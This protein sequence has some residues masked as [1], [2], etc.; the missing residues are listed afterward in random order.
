MKY[1]IAGYGRFGR[2]A[3]KR[4]KRAFPEREA[5]IIDNDIEK[6]SEK[7]PSETVAV[8]MDAVTFLSHTEALEPDDFI[9]PMVPFHLAAS[10]IMKRSQDVHEISL[11]DEIAT[12]A[13]NPIRI[14]SSTLLA[15]RADFLCPDDC[16]EG[17]RCT[18]TGRKAEPLYSELAATTVPGFSV[19]VQ[20]SYQILPGVGG[21]PLGDLIKLL[22][23]VA[24]GRYIVAT[25]CKC[26]AVLTAVEKN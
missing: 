24:V 8:N 15:T 25:S 26:H 19:L 6:L 14:S 16:P 17:V 12:K 18:I 23:K 5:L 22:S 4:L 1:L 11:P 21:Y 9:V 10:Y 7:L 3:L 2:I 20:Q 13:P